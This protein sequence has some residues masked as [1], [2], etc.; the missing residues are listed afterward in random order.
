MVN[1]KIFSKKLKSILDYY[2]LS[3]SGLADKIG[4]QRS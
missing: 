1:N 2:E 4:V 3:A